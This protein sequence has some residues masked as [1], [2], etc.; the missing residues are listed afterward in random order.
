M[1]FKQQELK[2]IDDRVE[3]QFARYQDIQQIQNTTI[4]G[5]RSCGTYQM[6]KT[7][8]TPTGYTIGSANP[9]SVGL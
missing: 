5:Y 4:N 2:S 7:T 3:R 8:S 1:F 6:V 9:P